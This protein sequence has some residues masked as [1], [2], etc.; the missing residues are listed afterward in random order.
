MA[1]NKV[2]I[3]YGHVADTYDD[4][5]GMRIKVRLNQ[6]RV[7]DS[8]LPYA[9]PLLPKT[10]QSM[11][12]R[13]EGV[14]IFTMELGNNQSQRFYIGPIISQ[15]Q[16]FDYDKYYILGGN[17]YQQAASLL[18]G[19]GSSTPVG[20]ISRYSDTW[21]AFPQKESVS[22]VGRKSEDIQLNANEIGI[23]CGIRK[24]S[25]KSNNDVFGNVILNT[26]DPAYIQLKYN[27]GGLVYGGDEKTNANS[28]INVVAQKINLVSPSDLSY[29]SHT[30][31]GKASEGL[32]RFSTHGMLGNDDFS[33][34]MEQ[35]H[36][37]PWGDRLVEYLELQ[38]KMFCEHSHPYPMLPPYPTYTEPL[39][40]KDLTEELL[41]KDVRIS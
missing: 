2:L 18:K 6:D 19:A 8:E 9:F 29:P 1:E 26:V 24:E 21:D 22:L 15:P 20:G 38:R 27:D 4:L 23:R 11:P 34:L 14:L 25:D 36:Q 32:E 10:I 35:L 13:G 37:L 31:N 41:S 5:D 39:L 16:F 40:E 12:K 3:Q 30:S 33:D 28:I 17:E 7:N